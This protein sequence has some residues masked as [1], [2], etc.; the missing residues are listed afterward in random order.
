MC[1][2]YVGLLTLFGTSL[3]SCDSIDVT[4]ALPHG[5]LHSSVGWSID[6]TQYTVSMCTLQDTTQESTCV[7]YMWGS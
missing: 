2:L 4:L 7:H 1:T 5:F 3:H 6:S